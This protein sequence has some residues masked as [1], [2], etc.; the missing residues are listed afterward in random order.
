MFDL[1]HN[2]LSE[3]LNLLLDTFTGLEADE[4]ADREVCAVGLADLLQILC[5]GLLAILSSY[6]DLII[7]ADLLELFVESADEH[8]LDDVLRFALICSL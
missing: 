6:I 8:L 7:Q 2:F 5:Y 3:V 4:A 1:A